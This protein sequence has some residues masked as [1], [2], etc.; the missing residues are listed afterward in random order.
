MTRRPQIVAIEGPCCAGKTTLS[1]GLLN[2]LR[3]LAF[4]H[5]HCYADHVGGGRFLP[6]P[7]PET[8]DEDAQALHEL[9]LIEQDRTAVALASG[10]DLVLL[11]R[12]LHTLL[13][14]RNAIERLA[15][16]ACFGLARRVLTQA[17]LQ[18]WPDLVL[19]LDVPQQDIHDRNNGK[20]PPD[21][22]FIDAIYN[23]GVRDYFAALAEQ[24]QPAVAWL[25]ATLAPAELVKMAS[26]RIRDLIR[27]D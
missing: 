25:D 18:S 7:V 11:D 20:F 23:A 3:D 5:V 2:A 12:G 4:A 22:I 19:Y 21:S 24:P 16:L 1:R 27:R 13:A 8:L 10:N 6:R 9:L 26:A 17:G 15:G 14:H